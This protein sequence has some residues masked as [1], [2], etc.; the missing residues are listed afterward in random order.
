MSAMFVL[1]SGSRSIVSEC[2][3]RGAALGL[4]ESREYC[5][6]DPSFK[7]NCYHK[8]QDGQTVQKI[9]KKNDRVKTLVTDYYY[10]SNRLLLSEV[11]QQ[12]F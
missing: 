2:V 9:D 6:S 12:K 8:K 1:V 4:L 7:K 5:S 3:A 11:N 10:I